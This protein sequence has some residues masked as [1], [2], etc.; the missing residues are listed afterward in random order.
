M[1]RL[2]KFALRGLVGLLMAAGMVRAQFDGLNLLHETEPVL[3]AIDGTSL[4]TVDIATGETILLGDLGVYVFSMTYSAQHKT[5]FA[6][7]IDAAHRYEN[8]L[9]RV[10]VNK[11]A[12]TPIAPSSSDLSLAWDNLNGVLYQLDLE[13]TLIKDVSFDVDVSLLQVD[14]ATGQTSTVG[15]LYSGDIFAAPVVGLT[16]DARGSLWALSLDSFLFAVDPYKGTSVV[17]YQLA[18]KSLPKSWFF[19]LN[20]GF[21]PTS[22]ILYTV[23]LDFDNNPLLVENLLLP[24]LGDQS[25]VVGSFSIRPTGFPSTGFAFGPARTVAP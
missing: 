23:G 6:V 17:S 9:Y 15:I 7:G 8:W 21:H 16:F 1:K 19:A 25:H 20:M 3:Y 13:V 11:V 24:V 5:F 22:N 12:A 14:P 2:A 18:D 4:H 10:D